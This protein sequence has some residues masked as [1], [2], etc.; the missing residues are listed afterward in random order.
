MN[1]QKKIK[2]YRNKEYLKW[3]DDGI[4]KI[5]YNSKITHHHIRKLKFGSGVGIKP[6]DYC[7][8]R[9]C[10]NCHDPKYDDIH[11][12]EFEILENLI[13]Y[14]CE[15]FGE[16]EVIQNLMEFVENKR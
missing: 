7:C 15:K 2:P 4:C 6:H 14:S 16:D 11:G 3:I 1:P 12:C 10:H 9:R 5:C 13:D 8:V